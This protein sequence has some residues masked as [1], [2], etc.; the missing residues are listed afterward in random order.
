MLHIDIPGFKTL[1]LDHLVLDLNGTLAFDG[2]LMIGVQ[3]HINALATVFQIHII[4][5]DTFGHAAEAVHG[6]RAKLSI[7][8]TP[9]QAEAKLAYI[10]ALGAEHV[11]CI[12]NGR[13]DR[14]MLKTAVLG[15]AVSGIE[16]T[17]TEAILAADLFI[18]RVQDALGLFEKSQRLIATL[19]S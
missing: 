6:L 19:R 2:K 13:N 5:A 8:G 7:L 17:A 12:G 11:V 15:I 18:P 14:L 16:G 1:E 10:E 4:T 3:E 9:D